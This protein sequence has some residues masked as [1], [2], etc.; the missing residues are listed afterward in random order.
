MI[1]ID[2]KIL[3]LYRHFFVVFTFCRIFLCPF[4]T[5]IVDFD[6][7]FV[8]YINS[9]RYFFRHFLLVACF[10][11]VLDYKV[12]EVIFMLKFVLFGIGL[13][14]IVQTVIYIGYK[15]DDKYQ[16]HKRL[17]FLK[18]MFPRRYKEEMKRK[19]MKNNYGKY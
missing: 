15:I 17:Q 16:E 13:M 11:S 1:K 4:P 9:S 19:E 5:F 2:V 12:V 14:T 3:T 8:V 18:K 6:A 10:S 7:C